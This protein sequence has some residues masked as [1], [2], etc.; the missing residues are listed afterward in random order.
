[1]ATL[2]STVESPIRRPCRRPSTPLGGSRTAAHQGLRSADAQLVTY[3]RSQGSKH[4]DR[5]VIGSMAGW[6]SP[7]D[8]TVPRPDRGGVSCQA[9]DCLVEWVSCQ[10]STGPCQRCS[11]GA[12][13]SAGEMVALGRSRSLG[14]ENL[15]E[16][17]GRIADHGAAIAR[18][19]IFLLD[20]GLVCVFRVHEAAMTDRVQGGRVGKRQWNRTSA[21][22]MAAG[23]FSWQRPA[24]MD[25]AV[26]PN[27][28]T[29]DR[30]Q[31]GS[32]Q[33]RRRRQWG[34]IRSDDEFAM[35]AAKWS[36]RCRRRQRCFVVVGDVSIRG[37]VEVAGGKQTRTTKRWLVVWWWRWWPEAACATASRNE[38]KQCP[39]RPSPRPFFFLS[40]LHPD[41][42]VACEAPL[43]PVHVVNFK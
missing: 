14:W 40:T 18:R 39:P 20:K 23:W 36:R 13:G 7:A 17:R 35:P 24:V 34:K 27:A 25:Q 16:H 41:Y 2:R 43:Q 11:S 29:L 30:D 42:F 19:R 21:G 26:A 12:A 33:A 9:A 10:R 32:Q 5:P 4:A 6:S 22:P 8:A 31:P 28:P 1:M 37:R 3:M 38:G 15:V